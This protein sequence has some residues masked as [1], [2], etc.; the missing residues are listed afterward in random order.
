MILDIHHVQITIPKGKEAQ[1]KKF[2]GQL[3][4]LSEIEKP[5]G[6]KGRGGFWLQVGDR[7]VHVGVEEGVDRRQTK[8]HVA[9]QVTDLSALRNKLQS[10][11]F[12]VIESIPLPSYDRFETRDPFGNRVEFIQRI[13]D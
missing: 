9:Y 2:Y 11:G 6:L 3:L 12:R 4:G 10:S 8:A 13:S 7:A 1:A 5:D